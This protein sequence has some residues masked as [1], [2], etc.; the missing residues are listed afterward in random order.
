MF[1]EINNILI[2]V[3]NI[4]RI[5]YRISDS[6]SSK[7]EFVIY[8]HTNDGG[9][10]VLNFTTNPD[11]LIFSSKVIMLKDFDEVD[12]KSINDIKIIDLCDRLINY[13]VLDQKYTSIE[14]VVS[15]L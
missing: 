5:Y 9:T 4:T 12:V 2:N 8:I 11:E 15:N 6:T 1:I 13:G 14:G 3:N 7:P 10:A